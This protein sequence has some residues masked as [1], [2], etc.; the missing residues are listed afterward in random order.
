MTIDFKI[1]GT[2][3]ISGALVD[4]F[5]PLTEVAGAIGDQIRVYRELSLIRSFEKARLIAKKKGLRMQPPPFKFLIPYMEDCSLED[6]EDE[7]LIEMWAHLLA[8]AANS[9]QSE[10]NLFSRFLKE[11]TSIEAH[12]LEY[13]TDPTRNSEYEEY[14]NF[15]D[16]ENS[17]EDTYI[18]QALIESI[19]GTSEDLSVDFPFDKLERI[20]RKSVEAPGTSIYHFS[21]A[22]GIKG[23]FPYDSMLDGERQPVH[24]FDLVSIAMVKSL[25]LIGEYKSTD[26][27]IDKF[28]FD[29]RAY[30]LSKLGCRFLK[31]CTSRK[32]SGSPNSKTT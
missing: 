6:S 23:E 1:E 8:S 21:V 25:G 13:L 16:T 12:F 2:K 9:Y 14:W 32:T 17:W 7:T 20:L 22:R 31:A 5:S 30:Y 10:H 27:W 3:E 29:V 11:L 15:E 26:L 19:K 18:H 28:E 24:D 4:L